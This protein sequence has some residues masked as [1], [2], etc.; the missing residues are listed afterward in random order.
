[1]FISRLALLVVVVLAAAVRADDVFYRVS[2]PDLRL[3]EGDVWPEAH[4][5][6]FVNLDA[7]RA[8]AVVDGGEAYVMRAGEETAR[9]INA[10]E[11]DQGRRDAVVVVRSPRGG[12]VTGR[13]FVPDAQRSR[14]MPLR[15]SIPAAKAM[16]EA[17]LAF[18]RGKALHYER[19]QVSQSPGTAWFRRQAEEARREL[20][21]GTVVPPRG[22]PAQADLDDTYNLF[23][24]G[25]AVAENLQL[26]RDL[27][28]PA[29]AEP[30][31]QPVPIDSIEGITVREM[32][33]TG[34]LAGASPALDPLASLV[35]ADQHAV[36]FPNFEALATL[37]DEMNGEGLPIF[38]S[39]MPRS[40]DAGLLAR[41]ELQLCLS[42]RGLARL[43]GP[44]AVKSVALTG[45]DPYFPTGTDVAVILE[46]ANPAGL[47]AALR[48]QVK[49]AA[50]G[51]GKAVAGQAGGLAYEGVATGDRVISVYVAALPKA[52]VVTNS[53][54]QLEK[55]G[56]VGT[57]GS[58]RLADLPEYRYFRGRYPL[59][60][61]S[62]TAFVFLSDATIRRWC[63]PRWRIGTSRRLR[64]A[65]L[66][67]DVTAAH[68]DE[69]VAGGGS[70]R[71][72]KA[73][74][75]MRTIGTLTL[76]P[77]GV[78]SSVYGSLGFIT[79]TAELDLDEVTKDEAS[80]YE[81]WR[82]GYQRNWSWA[83]DPIGVSI[84]LSSQRAGADMTIMPLIASSRYRTW[85][86][87]AQGVVIAP[88]A[89][90]PHD[91][92]MHG[93]MAFN[94][95]S[96][97]VQQWGGFARAMAPQIEIDP[98]SWLGSSVAVYADADAFWAEL[99]AATDDDAFMRE[100]M[101][102]LPVALYAEAS[103]PLKLTAFVAAARAFLDQSAPGM[104]AWEPREHA[105]QGYVKV[106]MSEQARQ[107]ARGDPMD[108]LG[109]YYAAMPRALIVSI[110]E[111]VLKRA[112]ER[113]QIRAT[114]GKPAGAPSAKPWLGS[115]LCLRLE[116][117]GIA[118]ADRYL[119]GDEEG[120]LRRRS[121]ANLPILNEWKRRYPSQDPVAL[122]RKVWGT[123]LACPA[124]GA[125]AWNE[126]FGTMA[127]AVCGHPGEPPEK[128]ARAEVLKGIS[129]A[130][131]GLTFEDDG[132][133]A[134]VELKR[135]PRK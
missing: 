24:G 49:A 44:L 10:W 46:S 112:I 2:G 96:P 101:W 19:L 127:S 77:S 33:W 9:A 30:P 56:G 114:G 76:G 13:I 68:M 129:G 103:S 75:S 87:I 121:W 64:A 124:G 61:E 58:T 117:A 57:A 12:D 37:A 45:S 80:A 18:H 50:A 93:A 131:F 82:T 130:D 110:N 79:P 102:R 16:P 59:G 116:S 88:D 36:F 7:L 120:A 95:R 134:R 17:G 34:R 85:M 74:V 25:R 48:A 67:A 132:L 5:S 51:A 39:A 83:F 20:G 15:F 81:R 105:G 43:L 6:G 28:V 109:V 94:A 22:G 41:Y 8:Y 84:R 86:S 100:N 125:Y 107:Q 108:Q 133:R 53:L 122:H 73:D 126:R 32:D 38:R 11:P 91:S 97:T 55:F 92:I 1:M 63:G 123:T 26:H 71:E 119:S 66:M 14:L 60:A 29:G 90:D 23:T 69:L 52:V 135:A 31:E 106:G 98:L 99:A 113:E 40:E 104:A 3:I 78:S 115:S 128:P 72:V 89:G 54:A 62:E 35:P 65:A 111:D 118:L 21:V 47:A 27:P 4:G 70:A 42:T